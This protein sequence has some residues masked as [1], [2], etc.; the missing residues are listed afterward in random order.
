MFCTSLWGCETA[1]F[2]Q[3]PDGGSTGGGSSGDGGGFVADGGPV[4]CDFG[5]YSLWNLVAPE[6]ITLAVCVLLDGGTRSVGLPLSA[7]PGGASYGYAQFSLRG[8]DARAFSV[9][10]APGEGKRVTVYFGIGFVPRVEAALVPLADG[11]IGITDGGVYRAELK[12]EWRQPCNLP[13][14]M[15]TVDSIIVQPPESRQLEGRVVFE[16]DD[17]GC[18]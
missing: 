1:R 4:R 16:G 13:T 12:V 15:S 6:P 11:G 3:Q 14:G 10:G 17:G 7:L 8:Q 5:E 9:G 2:Q 18:P